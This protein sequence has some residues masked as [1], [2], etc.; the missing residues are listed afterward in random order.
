[1]GYRQFV[2]GDLVTF[3]QVRIE[4]VFSGEPA[5]AGYLAVGSQSQAKG[6][7]HYLAVKDWKHSGHAKTNGAGEGIRSCTKLGGATAKNLAFGE[8]LGMNFQAD[9]CFVF[10]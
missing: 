5:R 1:L 2:L 9:N 7:L 8:K 4:I 6:E 10:H 3:R